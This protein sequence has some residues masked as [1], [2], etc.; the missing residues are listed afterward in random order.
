MVQGS[1]WHI[2]PKEGGGEQ[3]ELVRVGDVVVQ[4]GTLHAWEAGDEGARWVCVVVAAEPVR[5][6]GAGEGEGEGEGKVLEEVAF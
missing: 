3:R 6:G 1:A 4:R 5:V 2:T